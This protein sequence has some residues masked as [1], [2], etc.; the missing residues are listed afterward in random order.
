MTQGRI[1]PA[2]DA[3]LIALA[4]ALG[5]C[6]LSACALLATT[7]S[8]TAATQAR[9]GKVV[10]HAR[11]LLHSRALWATVDVCNP[12]DKPNTV[13]IRGS[14]PGDGHGKDTMYMRFQLQYLEVKRNV[15]VNLAHGASSS[16]IAVGPA[17]T[18]RQGGTSFML[19]PTKGGP[20]YTLRGSVTFQ[21]R[22]GKTVL[23]QVTRTT[24]AGHQSVAGADPPGYSAA[25][26]TIS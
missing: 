24:A 21:W 7:P 22:R 19:V 12:A 3:R 20:A 11:S 10:A 6:V 17:K 9:R 25:Q 1:R 4:P 26:C 2:S 14:M 18:A 23:H 15:W 5:A 8:A 16:F 13:G